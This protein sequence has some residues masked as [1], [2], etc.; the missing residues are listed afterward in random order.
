MSCKEA[1]TTYNISN[2][3]PSPLHH[4]TLDASSYQYEQVVVHIVLISPTRTYANMALHFSPVGPITQAL[5][6]HGLPGHLI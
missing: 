5:S 2:Y 1:I 6:K 3:S 4:P